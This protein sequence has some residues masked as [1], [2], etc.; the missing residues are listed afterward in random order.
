MVTRKVGRK[1]F[2]N[3]VCVCAH[4]VGAKPNRVTPGPSSNHASVRTA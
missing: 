1:Y 3:R 2:F 4:V